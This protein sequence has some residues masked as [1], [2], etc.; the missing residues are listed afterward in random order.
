MA[1]RSRVTVTVREDLLRALDNLIDAEQ[2]RNRSHALEYVL[3]RTLGSDSTQVVILA[4]G[5]G[6]KMRPFTYEV[7]KPL[8]PVHGKPLLEHTIGLLKAHGFR[9]IIITVS[10][11]A[12]KI[13]QYFGDGSKFGVQIRYVREKQ[14]SGTGVSLLKAKER[15]YSSPFLLV[16]GD[17][18][19]DL[20]IT[21]LKAAHQ[22][23][24]TCVATLALASVI[25]PSAYG[26]VRLRGTRVVDFSEKPDSVPGTSHLV[27][28]GC[29]MVEQRVFEFFPHS[30]K[31]PQGAAQNNLSLEHDVFPRL[32]E[33]GELHGYPFEGQWFDVSTPEIYDQVLKEWHKN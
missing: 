31:A 4:S 1:R 19:L 10:H 26:S 27:F 22:A 32:V 21:E 11:L 30:A 8:I 3:S 16:Y 9:E 12:D 24:R 17:V 5:E 6:V 23:H 25:D 13:E 33:H 20:D 28:A 15:L 14:S 18:L 29:A 2:I 7:P